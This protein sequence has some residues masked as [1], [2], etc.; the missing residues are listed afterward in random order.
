MS[1]SNDKDQVNSLIY[2]WSLH[3]ISHLYNY[4]TRAGPPHVGH[5]TSAD[6]TY[7]VHLT[8]AKLWESNHYEVWAKAEQQ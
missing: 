5:L 3:K 7:M 2:I 8:C 6:A 1:Y 4:K